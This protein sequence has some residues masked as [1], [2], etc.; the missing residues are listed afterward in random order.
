MPLSSVPFEYFKHWW[1]LKLISNI[2][3]IHLSSVAL[4][5]ILNICPDNMFKNSFLYP[6]SSRSIGIVMM[7]I[8]TYYTKLKQFISTHRGHNVFS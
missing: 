7:P 1:T 4:S 8:Y 5:A 2:S 3:S 6:C